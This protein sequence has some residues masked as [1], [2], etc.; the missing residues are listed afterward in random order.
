M[1]I[2]FRRN[3]HRTML[4]L[5]LLLI[6]LFCFQLFLA[7]GQSAGHPEFKIDNVRKQKLANE[8]K[9]RYEKDLLS[10]QGAN[11]KYLADVYKERYEYINKQLDGIITDAAAESYLNNLAGEIFKTNQLL[12]SGE[13]RIVFLRTASPNAS[14]MGEGTI[15]LNAGLFYRLENESQAAFI[16]CHEIA[17][18]YLNHSNNNIA[19]TV[20]TLHSSEFEK[21]LKKINKQQYGRNAEVEKLLKNLMF[22]N[23]HH[24][25]EFEESA[26]S[27][28]IELLKN[29]NFDIRESLTCLT[30]LDSVDKTKYN[31][32]FDLQKVFSFQNYPFKKS[33]LEE[34]GFRFAST[35][36]ELKEAELLKTH[37]DCPVRIERLRERV[38]KYY[39]NTTK[40]FAVNEQEFKKLQLAFDY[41][42][43]EHYMQVQNISMA[44]FLT[45]QTLQ[46]YPEDVNIQTIAGKCLNEIYARQKNHTLGKVID[47]PDPE[48]NKSY[49]SFLHFLQNLRLIEVAALSY[50]FLSR[51]QA[52]STTS[53]GFTKELIISKANFDRQ[54]EKQQW[55][56]FYKKNFP[57]SNQNF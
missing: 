48:L 9:I 51:Y 23:R 53:E 33:W 26:D 45:L 54:E 41:D 47:L 6:L 4:N 31:D 21:E 38:N 1:V 25:R 46:V 14:S 24:S 20:N 7:M 43:I 10:L 13:F 2:I 12:K 42:I 18:Y 27:L 39:R 5:R 16:L 36:E 40:K 19:Q 52:T 28:A 34:D 35:E 49:N 50:H 3:H 11:K 30:L 57:N 56:Q 22:K 17:H 32:G 15:F 8:V 37:P 55:I 44:L 29:T